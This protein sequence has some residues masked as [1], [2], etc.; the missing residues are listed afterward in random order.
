MVSTGVA[1]S[2]LDSLPGTVGSR[3]KDPDRLPIHIGSWHLKRR[4]EP[5]TNGSRI[6]SPGPTVLERPIATEDR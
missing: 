1:P 6:R 2:P 4:P 3:E 5:R